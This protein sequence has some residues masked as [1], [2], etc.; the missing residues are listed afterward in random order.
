MNEVVQKICDLDEVFP[1]VY[2]VF[3]YGNEKTPSQPDGESR[4][5][6]NPEDA[7]AFKD[8]YIK[9]CASVDIAEYCCDTDKFLT[10]IGDS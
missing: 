6:E 7:V 8:R 1:N 4:Y 9:H 2:K 10:Y 3:F 5:F